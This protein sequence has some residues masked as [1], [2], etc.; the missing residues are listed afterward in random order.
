MTYLRIN[1]LLALLMLGISINATAYEEEDSVPLTIIAQADDG[2]VQKTFIKLNGRDVEIKSA[3]RNEDNSVKRLGFAAST[4]FFSQ[5][6]DGEEHID[7]T[8]T[9][10]K[11]DLNGKN[12]KSLAY[13]RGFFLGQDVTEK[14]NT[15]GIPPIP[16]TNIDEKKLKRLPSLHGLALN[17]WQGYISYSWIASLPAKSTSWQTIRYK[18]LPQFERDEISSDRLSQRVL[19]HC[20]NPNE[21]RQYLA[22]LN[23]DTD[24]LLIEKYELP[25]QLVKTQDISIEVKQPIKNWLGARP[26]ISLMCGTSDRSGSRVNYSGVLSNV[27]RVTSVLVISTL[28]QLSEK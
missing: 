18:A 19:Q 12:L 22:D 25:V 10:L 28:N 14:L 4:P 15:V 2:N 26:I 6:G 16:N 23:L 27:G 5:L 1:P 9:D 11:V 3:I 24:A 7:K 20:G 13:R 17:N 8:F 21:I